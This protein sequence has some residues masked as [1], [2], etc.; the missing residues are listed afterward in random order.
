MLDLDGTL[1]EFDDFR[2]G[3]TDLLERLDAAGVA[4]AL[5][6]GR[7]VESMH[8]TAARLPAVRFVA[9]GGGSIVQ[10]RDGEG[11]RTLGERFLP[12]EQVDWIVD[13]AAEH[14]MELWAY[15][16][17]SWLVT[18][19]SE[20]VGFDARFTGVTPAVTPIAGRGDV[21]KLLTFVDRPGH[22]R[23]LAA[24]AGLD[25]VA[26]VSSFAGADGDASPF[27]API[28]AYFDVIPQASAQTKGGDVLI[29]AL[30][31][32]WSDVVAAGDG[33]NDLGMLSRAGTA[34]LMPP[35]TVAELEPAAAGQR[36]HACTDLH[37]ALALLE[38][39]GL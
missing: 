37:E 27:G 21:A 13:T 28:P 1:L 17:T 22:E 18:D 8:E 10:E 19:W 30:G 35:R 26:V 4:I 11:W 36:R 12:V 7:S 14:G 32:A 16:R 34:L 2:S 5:C 9:A 25:G 39:R 15:T 23:V 20:R 6:S 31:I 38:D 24:M 33:P 3:A 29:D